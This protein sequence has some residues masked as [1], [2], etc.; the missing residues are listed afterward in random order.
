MRLKNALGS[1]ASS[2]SGTTLGT[3]GAIVAIHEI[4]ASDML[5]PLLRLV[6][7]V[8]PNV[9]RK[10]MGTHCLST[11]RVG[12]TATRIR[13]SALTCIPFAAPTSIFFSARNK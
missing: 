8:H 3:Y 10:L 2:S 9:L 12:A 13:G 7:F 4:T 1:L 6:T 5:P 11:N